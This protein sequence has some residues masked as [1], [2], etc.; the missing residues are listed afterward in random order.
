MSCAAAAS[1]RPS[2]GAMRRRGQRDRQTSRRVQWLVGVVQA[3][4]SHHSG[5][6]GGLT[7][8]Q[9]LEN[10]KVHI[11]SLQKDHAT[12]QEAFSFLMQKFQEMDTVRAEG[13]ALTTPAASAASAPYVVKQ[14]VKLE[15]LAEDHK[16]EARP[17][18]VPWDWSE[19]PPVISGFVQMKCEGD[20]A[21]MK[22]ATDISSMEASVEVLKGAKDKPEGLPGEVNNMQPLDMSKQ[23]LEVQMAA[24]KMNIDGNKK[25]PALER[26]C[27]EC[28]VQ[29]SSPCGPTVC[30]GC[31]EQVMS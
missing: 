28:G 18:P 31:Y 17:V 29:L 2:G 30:K 21:D 14:E 16:M 1:S 11:A 26:K 6:G 9:E 13:T 25:A 4:S 20:S 3:S 15:D 10:L 8:L 22:A 5:G 24:D 19:A 7:L 27:I 23:S 12:L